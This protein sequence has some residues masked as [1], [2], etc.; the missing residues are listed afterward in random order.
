MRDFDDLVLKFGIF[1]VKVAILN[2]QAHNK[3]QYLE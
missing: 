3:P 1:G 2:A